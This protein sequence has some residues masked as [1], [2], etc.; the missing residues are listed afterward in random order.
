MPFHPY[1]NDE[2]TYT[3]DTTSNIE[4]T[5][6]FQASFKHVKPKRGPAARR[7]TTTFAI[8]EDK[9]EAGPLVSADTRTTSS[10]LSQPAKRVMPP[11]R[12]HAGADVSRNLARDVK[13]P[14]EPRDAKPQRTSV[15]PRRL[16]PRVPIIPKDVQEEN[17]VQEEVVRPRVGKEVRRKTL[18][19]PSEDTTQP[20]MWMGIFSPV[21]NEVLP[22]TRVDEI[23]PY[24]LT[25]IAA[26][27]AEKRKRRTS[28]MQSKAKRVPLQSNSMAQEKVIQEDRAGAPTGKE[29]L[30]P[31][32]KRLVV[33][34]GKSAEPAKKSVAKNSSVTVDRD[35]QRRQFLTQ[36]RLDHFS[37]SK[38]RSSCGSPDVST[39]YEVGTGFQQADGSGSRKRVAWNAGPKVGAKDDC[40]QRTSSPK[41]SSIIEVKPQ[42]AIPAKVPTKFVRPLVHD[43]PLLQQYVPI[44]EHID[45]P[46]MYEEDWLG[47]Q[48]IAITQL[49]NSLFDQAHGKGKPNDRDEMR[50]ELV[51]LYNSP[52]IA[53]VHSKLQAALLYGSLSLTHEAIFQMQ[54]LVNDVGRRRQYLKFWIDNYDNDL[55]QVALEVV[56]GKQVHVQNVRRSAGSSPGNAGN[57]KALAQFI[58]ASLLR[59]EDVGFK[60]AGTGSVNDLGSR[61][62]LRSLMLVK[63]LDILQQQTSTTSSTCLFRNS[64]TFKSSVVAVQTLMRMLNPAVG[65]SLRALR[66]LGYEVHHEQQAI[67][68][69]SHHVENIAVDLRDGVA[70]TRLV[71]LLLHR[72][73]SKE[74]HRAHDGDTNTICMPEGETLLIGAEGD[75]PLSQHLKL[76]CPSRAAKLWNVQIAL[77]ALRNV[78]GISRVIENVSADDIV[79]G[80]REKTVKLL[81]SLV[82]Q[83][84][85]FG[86]V[87][88]NDLKQEIRRLSRSSGEGVA[89][90]DAIEEGDVQAKCEFLLKAWTKAV[91]ASKGL[92][93]RNFTTSFSDGKVF[94]TILDEYEPYLLQN[95][96]KQGTF[97]ERLLRLGCSRQFTE[98]FSHQAHIFGKDFVLAALAFLCSRVVGLSKLCRKAV[99]IQRCW[100]RYQQ[101]VQKKRQVVKRDLA[102][103]C[104]AFVNVKQEFRGCTS[105]KPPVNQVPKI[106]ERTEMDDDIWVGL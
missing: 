31:D 16:P 67:E 18:Y 86:M 17:I 43:Q 36:A 32:H 71:E 41:V 1:T 48:E 81:W 60:P 105:V 20:T 45:N 25:G 90:M 54:N 7:G 70:L 11:I 65:D 15:A 35:F 88:Q 82:G 23:Q 99:T 87:D 68:E 22:S 9:E 42:E 106:D 83:F 40:R 69:V 14:A 51:S 104:A 29:N 49:L 39:L 33:K 46:A 47:Q 59:N 103:A 55:L 27:M 30:P 58:E 89:E 95:E 6:A 101:A 63:A 37:K 10:T 52:E 85:L 75:F 5:T 92:M 38:P 64:A 19:M 50:K 102:Q 28:T 53:L 34:A 21:K 4:F 78:Q 77:A 8:H 56:T 94:E 76:P 98:L 3:E 74:L 26:Q 24:D 57:R 73:S 91:A 97:Q 93:V 62:I 80:Y 2:N 13:G 12:A 61:T 96:A 84:G 66:Q 44:V 79:D 100:R 72:T